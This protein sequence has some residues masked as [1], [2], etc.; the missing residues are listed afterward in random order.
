MAF[1]YLEVHG[2]GQDGNEEFL[3]RVLKGEDVALVLDD[4]GLLN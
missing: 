4:A 3:M 2:L 1:E